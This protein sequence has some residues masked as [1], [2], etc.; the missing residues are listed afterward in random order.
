MKHIW[1]PWRMTYLKDGIQETGCL[2]CNRLE[3]EDGFENL[4][5]FRGQHSFVMLN[6]YP[7]TNGH[8]MIVPFEHRASLEG[9][10]TGTLSELMLL[11]S[12]S[13]EILRMAYEAKSFNV[14]LNIGEAA[15]AG[16]ADHVHIHVL[17]RWEG[18]TNFMATTAETRVIPE[19]LETTFTKLQ[20]NWKE[21]AKNL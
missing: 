2:F 13:L 14:G 1:A 12:K 4:I 20:K 11:V 18:D 8:M 17:P 9:L 3:Q 16:V 10:Q 5:L 7:Y 21:F 19:S 6:L 15:G